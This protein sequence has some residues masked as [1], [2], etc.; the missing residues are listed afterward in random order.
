MPVTSKHD[1]SE[2]GMNVLTHFPCPSIPMLLVLLTSFAFQ[3]VWGRRSDGPFPSRWRSTSRARAWE[4]L[5]SLLRSCYR[6]PED[7]TRSWWASR[8]LAGPDRPAV[9]FVGLLSGGSASLV[10]KAHSDF[11]KKKSADISSYDGSS[12]VS[13]FLISSVAVSD[14]L[15]KLY[16]LHLPGMWL[17]AKPFGLWWVH[18]KGGK[19]K[20][21]NQAFRSFCCTCAEC[22]I[23]G[24]GRERLL[25][26]VSVCWW[27]CAMQRST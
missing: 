4:V 25:Y 7:S 20:E 8:A 6:W 13:A 11:K 26:G 27:A 2:K 16:V 24:W 23:L 1:E 3:F 22:P 15:W 14:F 18:V 12:K 10:L 9:T 19:K 17:G 5:V 21:W